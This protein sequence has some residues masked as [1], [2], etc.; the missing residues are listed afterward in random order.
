MSTD[1]YSFTHT[2]LSHT[3]EK[4]LF[5]QICIKHTLCAKH[6]AKYRGGL[7]KARQGPCP[8]IYVKGA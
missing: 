7:K 1:P 2:T 8:C 3:I 4:H 6:L 5:Q